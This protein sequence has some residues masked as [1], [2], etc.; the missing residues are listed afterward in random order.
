MIIVLIHLMTD[1]SKS[2]PAEDDNLDKMMNASGRLLAD[3]SHRVG[4]KLLVGDRKHN[5]EALILSL[6]KFS[7]Y[8]I[9]MSFRKNNLTKNY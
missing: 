2:T 8:L 3:T 9:K 6:N 1:W 4:D 5:L 7:R